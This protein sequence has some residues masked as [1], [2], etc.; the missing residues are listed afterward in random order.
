MSEYDPTALRRPDI[1]I[2]KIKK[3]KEKNLSNTAI[4]R[5][6]KCGISTVEDR[7]RKERNKG[8]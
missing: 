3:L 1:T 5:I 6:L 7:I 8:K 2:D 4:A